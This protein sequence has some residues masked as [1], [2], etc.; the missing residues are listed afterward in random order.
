MVLSA[1]LVIEIVIENLHLKSNKKQLLETQKAI[2]D[3][4]E[5][6]NKH[7]EK[8]QEELSKGGFT[9]LEIDDRD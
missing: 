4:K 1:L 7:Y 8:S 6:Q 2:K 5:L 3:L 9:E